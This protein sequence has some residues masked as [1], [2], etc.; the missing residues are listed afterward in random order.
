[1]TNTLQVHGIKAKG[2]KTSLFP[3]N[4]LMVQTK[5]IQICDK[6]CLLLRHIHSKHNY[7]FVSI[8]RVCCNH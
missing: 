2:R 1:M 4:V 7:K 6:S 3:T 5:A 8:I